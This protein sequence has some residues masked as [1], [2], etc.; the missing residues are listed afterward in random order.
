MGRAG[1]FAVGLVLLVPVMGMAQ[2]AEASDTGRVVDGRL[3]TDTFEIHYE[4][5]GDT[6]L[7]SIRSDLPDNATLMVSVDRWYWEKG[8]SDTYS[9]PY[10][11]EKS[12]VGA[13]EDQTHRVAVDDDW[14]RDSLQ[15]HQ[16]QMA[17]M[18]VPYEVR[19]VEDTVRVDF[20]VPVNQDDPRFGRGNENLTGKV[21][22]Q[23]GLRVVDQE[24]A[25]HKPLGEQ[26][27]PSPWVS[28]KGLKPGNTYSITESAP[29]MPAFEPRDPIAAA[30][31]AVNMPAGTRITVK[32]VRTKQGNP[33]YRVEAF[34]PTGGS[35]GT[36]WLNSIALIGQD[37]RREGG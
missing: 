33:W 29:L 2:Q 22:R 9:L 30:A 15:A 1:V 23:E 34:S 32:E 19:R 17:G 31:A 18:G 8:S 7:V 20:T 4:W 36:G 3:V 5:Q 35:L 14:W 27:E 16:R 28:G 37:I 10:L 26:P 24:V 6:L 11:S 12:R 21:V 13:W 25:L